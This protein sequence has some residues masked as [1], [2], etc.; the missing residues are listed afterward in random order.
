MLRSRE[1]MVCLRVLCG[2]YNFE[3]WYTC[4]RLKRRLLT[5]S[6]TLSLFN[7]AR[8]DECSISICIENGS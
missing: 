4:V 3:M 6:S 7:T 5:A 1:V 8:E 2:V